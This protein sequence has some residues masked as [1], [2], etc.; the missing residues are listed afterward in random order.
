MATTFVDN[1]FKYISLKENSWI[2]NKISL[3]YVT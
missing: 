2:L 3:K 1:I